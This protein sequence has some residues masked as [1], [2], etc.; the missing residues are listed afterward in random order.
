MHTCFRPR[1][2]YKGQSCLLV[3]KAVDWLGVTMA[4]IHAMV[5]T[6]PPWLL[7]MFMNPL[8]SRELT[9]A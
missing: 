4:A 1:Y 2:S 5:C 8:Y 3:V 9:Y 7:G 6:G